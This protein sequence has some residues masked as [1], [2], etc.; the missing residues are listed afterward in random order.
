MLEKVT[1]LIEVKKIIALLITLV[2]VVLSLKGALNTQEIMTIVTSVIFFYF[3]Q[4]TAK[5][6]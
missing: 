1:K 3:G 6:K 2:F 4:S 5:E